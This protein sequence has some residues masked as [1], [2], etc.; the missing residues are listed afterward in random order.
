M[1]G[2]PDRVKGKSFRGCVLD[3]LRL[4]GFAQLIGIVVRKKKNAFDLARLVVSC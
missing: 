4:R 2:F 3:G 1:N